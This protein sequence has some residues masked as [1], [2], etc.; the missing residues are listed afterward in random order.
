MNKT[1]TAED[2]LIVVTTFVIAVLGMLMRTDLQGS[3]IALHHIENYLTRSANEYGRRFP[4]IVVYDRKGKR[5]VFYTP[6]KKTLI[7]FDGC[8]CESEQIEGTVQ[9][10]QQRGYDVVRIVESDTTK[11]HDIMRKHPN[12]NGRIVI[13]R[14]DETSLALSTNPVEYPMGYFLDVHGVVDDMLTLHSN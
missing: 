14:V 8:A 12:I 10:A 4:Q 1:A 2:I 7:V 13:A 11:I 5:E 3:V 9:V 6:G